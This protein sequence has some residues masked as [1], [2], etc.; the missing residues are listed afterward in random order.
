M[1]TPIGD[2][3]IYFLFSWGQAFVNAMILLLDDMSVPI[4]DLPYSG[5]VADFVFSGLRIADYSIIDL[6]FGAGIPL[7]LM[8]CFWRFL[9]GK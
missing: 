2:Q 3:I 4:S 7:L 9:D 1:D 6:F 5:P 8:I